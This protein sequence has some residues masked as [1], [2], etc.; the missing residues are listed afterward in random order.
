MP[1]TTPL[2][3]TDPFSGYRSLGGGPPAGANAPGESGFFQTKSAPTNSLGL[4]PQ[5]VG[6]ANDSLTAFFRSLTN[7]TGGTGAAQFNQG[8]QT[9]GQGMQTIGTG[10]E[11]QQ[12]GFDTLNAPIEFYQKLLDG[13]PAAMAAALAPTA[14]LIS[15]T[16]EGAKTATSAGLPSGGFRSSAVA[17]LPFAQASKVGD[18]A[19]KL[20]PEAAKQLGVLG[21]ER[22]GI[23][24]GI[25]DTG[26]GVAGVGST[27]Q[28][29]GLQALMGTI[30]DLLSK[31][32]INI[33]GGTSN[34]FATGASGIS[35]IID[36]LVGAGHRVNP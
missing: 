35:S 9:I 23:G 6:G 17:G 8:A 28:S 30:T 5:P 26:L 7:L 15:Q 4:T 19:L 16:Y 36:S 2:S 10:L 12:K 29:Q 33:Q 21:G 32:G 1:A 18:E 14:S 3:S 20:Q 11:D 24:R 31:M 25:S 22:A 27:Q 13:D 34:M